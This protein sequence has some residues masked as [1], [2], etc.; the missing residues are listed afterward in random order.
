MKYDPHKN[1]SQYLEN[2][3]TS[4]W[5]SAAL[6]TALDSGLFEVL[7]KNSNAETAAV[8]EAL[9]W[10]PGPADRFLKLLETLGLVGA[11][12]GTWYLTQLSADHLV[13]GAP[14]DQRANIRWRESLTAEW[15]TLPEVLAAGT[16]TLFPS[17][18]VSEADMERRRTAYLQA[19]DAVIADKIDEMLPMFT[20]ALPENAAVLDVGCGSG[21]FA[22]SVLKACPTATATLMDIRQ[23][24]PI[25]EAHL[26]SWSEA[27]YSRADCAAQNV[28]EHPWALDQKYDLI[29]LSN[30]VHATAEAESAGVLKEAA[31]HLAPGGFI[32]VHDFFTEHDP[33]KSRL[34]DLNM[35]VNTY[36]GRAYSAKWTADVLKKAGCAETVFVPLSTDTGVVFASRDAGRLD[37]LALDPVR[38]LMPALLHLGFADVLPLDPDAVVFAPFSREKCVYGC[39]SAFSKT[40][41]TNRDMSYDETQAL[42]KDYHHALLLC[43][44]PPT[45]TFQRRCLAAEGEAF[46]SGFYKAFVFWAGPCSI[47]EVCDP[48]TPCAN[49]SHHRPSMEGSGIDVYATV[50][51]AGE[52]L[53]PLRRR[54]EIAKYYGLLLLD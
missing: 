35:M 3:A 49:P 34:S 31:A 44:E 16:R 23:M 6:F 5:A 7:Q 24:I 33:V 42:V 45:Q 36:N 17:E 14:H 43:S 1:G 39:D 52:A 21:L 11:Y 29:I 37:D 50:R 54:D 27:V 15:R 12:N 18:D 51:R 4:Y 20:D 9:G 41:I 8:A 53:H 40:C 10:Q 26:K 28:L 19:M 22:L 47:C 38:R 30:I 25:I 46:K 13:P 32:L 2:L 48:D